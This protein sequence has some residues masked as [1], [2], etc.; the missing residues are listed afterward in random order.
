MEPKYELILFDLDGTLL[1][2]SP[3]IFNSVRYAEK[4][5]GFSPVS[6]SQLSEFVGPPPKMMYMKMYGVKE[7]TALLAAQKHR[8]YGREKAI[9]EATVYQGVVELLKNLKIQGYKLGVCT[10]KNQKIA[11]TIL[12]NFDLLQY[13]D[14]I[15]GMDEQ[16]TFTKC[17]TIQNAIKR[18]NTKGKVLMVGDSQYDYEGAI[19]ARIDFLGVVYGFGF[20]E[21]EKYPFTSIQKPCDLLEIIQ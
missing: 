3:G 5:M 19:K 17:L 10:L 4:E 7:E 13:F 18:T 8:E 16:E 9:L 21:G 2:T 15:V 6:S 12:R 1:D 14:I 20:C 11:E